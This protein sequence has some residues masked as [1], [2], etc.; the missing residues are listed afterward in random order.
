MKENELDYLKSLFPFISPEQEN[1][2]SALPQLYKEWNERINVISRKDID[3]I[4]PHHILHSLAV[5]KVFPFLEG[6]NILDIGTGGGFPGIPLAILFPKCNF[7]LVDRTAKKIKVVNAVKQALNL[8]N[9]CA[10]QKAA[11][12]IKEKY[13]FIVSR[14]VTNMEDFLKISKNKML[15]ENRHNK[16][17][18]ILYLKG[19]D[20]YEEM[21]DYKGFY[22]IFNLKNIFTDPYFETKC[23]VYI[24]L[25]K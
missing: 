9:V 13:D 20:A 17:N 14:A 8:Q 23:L 19:T 15:K 3:N 6:S 11:E 16:K 24:A 12:D 4:F 10:E 1:Q 21:S 22:E 18:G 25:N 7:R 2:F 5:G